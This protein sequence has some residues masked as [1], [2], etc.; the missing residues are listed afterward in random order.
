MGDYDPTIFFI[1]EN[2]ELG[3]WWVGQTKMR[4]DM[5]GFQ[6]C[7]PISQNELIAK[8]ESKYETHHE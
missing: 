2:E 3:T 6:K 7:R 8:L 5:D 1:L 4:L